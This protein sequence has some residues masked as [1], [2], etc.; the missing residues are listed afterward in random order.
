MGKH[1]SGHKTLLGSN[2]A[3]Q[4]I[5]GKDVQRKLIM[6]VGW[7]KRP[8]CR[9]GQVGPEIGDRIWSDKRKDRAHPRVSTE[10]RINCRGYSE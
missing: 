10:S 9:K 8:S 6:E 2:G 7:S 1:R 4:T 5:N 3:I